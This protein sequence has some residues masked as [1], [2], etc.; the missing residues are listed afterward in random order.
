MRLIS[1]IVFVFVLSL[2]SVGCLESPPPTPP[3]GSGTANSS[4]STPNPS[5]PQTSSSPGGTNAAPSQ[6]LVA[7]A[8]SA[9][10]WQQDYNRLKALGVAYIRTID[11]RGNGPASW[12]DLP[13]SPEFASLQQAGCIVKWGKHF[14]DAENGTSQYVLAYLPETLEK[15]GAVLLM[16]GAVSL[17]SAQDIKGMLAA[18]GE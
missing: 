17:L 11:S 18:Q 1:Q 10:K 14:R 16:D 9:E 7:E 3:A 12:Q 2:T 6:P 4:T 5:A 8:G 13:Q 15:G